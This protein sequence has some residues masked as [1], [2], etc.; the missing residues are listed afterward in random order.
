MLL[1]F[2]GFGPF[3]TDVDQWL[4]NSTSDSGVFV[5]AHVRL[6]WRV[7]A[8]AYSCAPVRSFRDECW[9]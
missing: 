7:V 4:W 3:E 9:L 8:H 5:S 6:F 2:G 1:F